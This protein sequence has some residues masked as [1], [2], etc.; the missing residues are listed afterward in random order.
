MISK[1]NTSIFNQNYLAS[2]NV[3]THRITHHT[4]AGLIMCM[5]Y[6][7]CKGKSSSFPLQ[8]PVSLP[9]HCPGIL[10]KKGERRN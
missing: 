2:E 1:I 3:G 5:M 7:A 9:K 6:R 4:L 10:P 8:L